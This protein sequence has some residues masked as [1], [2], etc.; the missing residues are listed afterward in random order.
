MDQLQK[1]LPRPPWIRAAIA[2]IPVIAA[3]LLGQWAT[4]PNLVSW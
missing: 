2:V 3:S 4:F 1:A